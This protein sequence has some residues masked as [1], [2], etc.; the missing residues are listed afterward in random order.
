MLETDVAYLAGLFDGEGHIELQFD[1][2]HFGNVRINIA[3]THLETIEWIQENWGG[4]IS[5]LKGRN[6]PVFYIRW[7]SS[8]AKD[9]LIQL[10]PYLHIKKMQA[11]FTIELMDMLVKYKRRTQY[12]QDE[13]FC[14][15]ELVYAIDRD[16]H[17]SS[18]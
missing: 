16:K 11:E 4:N 7:N 8:K 5:R 3:N 9:I 2:T 12:T 18:S 10:V 17:G 15:D 13:L 14:I 6:N 1:K